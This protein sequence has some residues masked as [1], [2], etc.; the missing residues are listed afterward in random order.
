MTPATDDACSGDVRIAAANELS[1]TE[2]GHSSETHQ[3]FTIA[4][5]LIAFDEMANNK[6]P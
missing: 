5:A 4:E 2:S 1:S 6:A 3:P